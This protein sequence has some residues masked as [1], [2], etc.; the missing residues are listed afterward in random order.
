MTSGYLL[1]PAA[2]GRFSADK[3]TKTD[4]VRGTQLFL[5][6]NCFEPGQSQ[7]VHAHR[8]ADKFY[9]IVSGKASMIVGDDRFDAGP[10]QVVWAPADVPHGV[11]AALERTIMMI[12]MAPPP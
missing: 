10:G 11:A 12:G 3:A 6:L 5:G 8:G 4:L 1:D 9:L 7:P 2:A